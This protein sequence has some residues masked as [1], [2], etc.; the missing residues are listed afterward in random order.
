MLSLF[1]PTMDLESGEDA[2]KATTAITLPVDSVTT[3]P[4][5]P[6]IGE[7]HGKSVCEPREP[8]ISW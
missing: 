3:Y 7:E 8:M 4:G 2:V 1:V 6:C 5:R